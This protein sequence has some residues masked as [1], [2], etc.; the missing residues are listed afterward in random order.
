MTSTVLTWTS[1]PVFSMACIGLQY[2]RD[3]QT[4]LV[5]TISNRSCPC[6]RLLSQMVP[7]PP[8]SSYPL[9]TTRRHPFGIHFPIGCLEHRW[10][11][12][13]GTV[14][15][16]SRSTPFGQ[17]EGRAKLRPGVVDLFCPHLWDAHTGLALLLDI[18]C[19]WPLSPAPDAAR[20][21]YPTLPWDLAVRCFLSRHFALS[22]HSPG[23]FPG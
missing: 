13:G 11:V 18:S 10:A 1:V 2:K 4:M 23:K 20:G 5:L 6:F 8:G 19:A 16:H 7:D 9:N 22:P 14:V 3:L 17:A 15:G 21:Q 12:L